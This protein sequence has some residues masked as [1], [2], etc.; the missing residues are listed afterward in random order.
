MRELS[1]KN[2]YYLPKDRYLEMKHFALQYEYW[3][4]EVNSIDILGTAKIERI[5]SGIS[6]PVWTAYQRRERYLR[7]MGMVEE[8]ADATDDVLGYFTFLTATK[9][10]TYENLKLMHNIP[11][12]RKIFYDMLRRFYFIL[13]DIRN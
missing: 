8:A 11:C 9:G 6:D 3:K 5:S 2:P 13:S 12:C 1:Q 10:C 4:Q 7:N